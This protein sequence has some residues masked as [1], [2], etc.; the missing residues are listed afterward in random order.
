MAPLPKIRL[1]EPLHAFIR[2][3]VDF[4]GPF[5]SIQGRGRKRAKRYL[6]L[7]TCLLSR[8]VHLEMAY[9]LDTDS[10]LNAFY[11]MVSRRGLPEEVL[12]DNGSNFVGGKRELSELVNL[13]DNEKICN[14]L[15][16][17]GI[18]WTF[19]P[20][21]APHFGGVH[22]SMIKSAKR[23]IYAVLNHADIND[24]ELHSAFVGVEDLLNSRPLTYQSS[25][26]ND[27]LPLTPN[28]FLHGRIG[29]EFAPSNVDDLAYSM[30]KRW[31]RVQELV[32]H[33]WNRWM[34][35][36]VPEL[37]RRQ[38][39]TTKNRDFQVGDMVLVIEKDIPRGQWNMGKIENIY[40]GKDGHVRTVKVKVRGSLYVRPITKLCHLELQY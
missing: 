31:R 14:S 5:I 6:C 27:A 10:F 25:H 23:A 7:F 21:L 4:A 33:V 28:Q 8:A 20:P 24:E 30:R 15:A 40:P 34:Q 1:K 37:R 2:V 12:S 11:R 36:W 19:N 13:L 3:S 38:K 22:E 39:W 17:K 29:G 9:S 32:R 18:K 16:N 26:P 35:E